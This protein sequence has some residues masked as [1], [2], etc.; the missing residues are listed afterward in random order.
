MPGGV[1]FLVCIPTV[2]Y[3]HKLVF[4]VP[5]KRPNRVDKIKGKVAVPAATKVDLRLKEVKSRPQLLT[6]DDDRNDDDV[7]DDD[8]DIVTKMQRGYPARAKSPAFV[9][10]ET[11]EY[12]G[13]CY[14][15]SVLYRNL[16]VKNREKNSHVFAGS[17][18]ATEEAEGR[19][20]GVVQG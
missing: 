18:W 16:T 19:A 3:E 2:S 7:E 20:R 1:V 14:L 11:V 8:D 5:L 17:G 6:L 9:S 12:D 13:L 10:M 4:G 15:I